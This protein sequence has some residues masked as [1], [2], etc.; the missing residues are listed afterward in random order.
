MAGRKAA[1][2]EVA[3]EKRIVALAQPRLV[4]EHRAAQHGTTAMAGTAGGAE[5][6]GGAQSNQI[7]VR[8]GTGG[9]GEGHVQQ[10]A[11][12]APRHHVP[13]HSVAMG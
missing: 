10:E 6:P 13:Q 11:A 3:P 9:R 5:I 7:Q 1:A 8:R 4:I 2:I 12:I